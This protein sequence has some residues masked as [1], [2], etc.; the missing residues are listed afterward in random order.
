[1]NTREQE[2]KAA[3]QRGEIRGGLVYCSAGHPAR[4]NGEP[5][6]PCLDDELAMENWDHDEDWRD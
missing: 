6:G 2:L 4:P 1:M 3:D 5:C